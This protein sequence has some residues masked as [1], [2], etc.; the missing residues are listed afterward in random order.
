MMMVIPIDY[1]YD[2][3][4][5][6]YSD[7]NNDDDDDDSDDDPRR[8]RSEYTPPGPASQDFFTFPAEMRAG[9]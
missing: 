1:H 9:M 5:D 2:E 7:D 8:K 3:S 6:D 4:G